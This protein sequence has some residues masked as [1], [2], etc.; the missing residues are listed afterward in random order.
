MNLCLKEIIRSQLKRMLLWVIL[1][2][3]VFLYLLNAGGGNFMTRCLMALS[4]ILILGRIYGENTFSVESTFFDKFMVSPQRSPYLILKIKYTICVIHVA[5]N[6]IISIIVCINRVSILF[7][8]SIFFYGCGILLF[9]FFQNVVYN[10]RRVDILSFPR[11]FSDLTISSIMLIILITLSTG[12]IVITIG[13]L[14]SEKTTEYI[15]LITG[16]V[17][18]T[19]SPFWLKNI[20]NRF[21][22]RK[23]QTMDKFRN[24]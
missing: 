3:I 23:Y 1:L 13:G 8:L 14:T 6:A 20:Y 19:T 18:M 2:F 16:I 24:S 4:P 22:T 21:L 15:L 12:F 10:N 11:K 9:F 5:I 7:W 17:G